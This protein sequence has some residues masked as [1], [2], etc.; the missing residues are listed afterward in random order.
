MALE[1]FAYKFLLVV[2]NLYQ[3]VQYLR[4]SHNFQFRRSDVLF[5]FNKVNLLVQRSLFILPE[6]RKP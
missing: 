6:S 1:M 5:Y 3:L 2:P 4:G